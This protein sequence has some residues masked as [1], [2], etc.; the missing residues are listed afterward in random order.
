MKSGSGRVIGLSAVVFG[1][2]LFVLAPSA[3]G[4]TWLDFVEA[5]K[6][7]APPPPDLSNLNGTRN[8]KVSPDGRHLYS[9][10]PDSDA[11]NVFSRDD[12]TGQLT[13]IETHKDNVGGVDGLDSGLGLDI[14]PDGTHIYVASENDHG[15]SLFSRNPLTG[16]LTFMEIFQDGA[17]GID[18]LN[19]AHAV[20]ISPD[21]KHVYAG[22]RD[23]FGVFSRNQAT[24][25]LTFIEK[26]FD[27]QHAADCGSAWTMAVS[28]DGKHLYLA[29]DTSVTVYSRNETTGALTYIE[30]NF[31]G[32]TENGINYNFGGWA[33]GLS[34][35]P[36]GLNV[37]TT[38][39]IGGPNFY[40]FQRNPSTGAL[41]PIQTP[42]SSGGGS[43]TPAVEPFGHHVYLTNQWSNNLLVYSRSSVDGQLTYIEEHKDGVSGVDGLDT[44]YGAYVSP[45]GRHV[46]TGS[47][48]GATSAV[49]V[50]RASVDYALTV[51]KAGSGSGLV[52]S[53]PAG[54][55]C[56]A[57]CS[58][59]YV[60]DA[61][62]SLTADPEAGSLFVGWSGD[63]SGANPQIAIAMDGD[64]S[65]M[66]QFDAEAAA[67]PVVIRTYP[68]HQQ[69]NV[70]M[71]EVLWAEFSRDMAS[72]SINES[73]F[74]LDALNQS[75]TSVSGTISYDQQQRKAIFS[76]SDFL[77]SGMEYQARLTTEVRAEDGMPLNQDYEWT[78]TTRRTSAASATV[79]LPAGTRVSDYRIISMPLVPAET[80]G[81]GF[82]GLELG[83][84]D[85]GLW[86]IGRW[87][88]ASGRYDQYPFDETPGPGWAGW[89]LCRNGSVWNMT[90]TSTP[91]LAGPSGMTGHVVEVESGWNQIGN[92]FNQ[93][94]NTAEVWVREVG[95][96]WVRIGEAG[97]TITQTVFWI[98]LNGRYQAAATLASTEG[99]WI[100][101]LTEG[102]GE[103]FFPV[104]EPLPDG[105]AITRDAPADLERP[106]DPPG[107]LDQSS[108]LSGG[109]GGGGGCFIQT[110][111]DRPNR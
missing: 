84:Y 65:C 15:L 91:I 55:D 100:K 89:F 53:S 51:F 61:G 106:P 43:I 75:T 109:G 60:Q 27:G 52:A 108:A 62:I 70:L 94:V 39:V 59:K 29:G 7:D 24:G 26:H 38:S 95:G 83:V 49:S 1:V 19:Q 90:G 12:A 58:K 85:T 50:F 67:P 97:N 17:D 102:H 28:P 3:Q 111:I 16:Q 77:V 6:A 78:F 40:V 42:F 8:V 44:A 35:S 23:E 107:G 87:N 81:N 11:L 10:A 80:S 14:S 93:A 103:V 46:Y 72:A 69:D 63:A 37:Y 101:K 18:G 68:E 13:F 22:G 76:P 30:S 54:I 88:P 66:A 64:K 98:Y 79:S 34:I 20:T 104:Q 105:S 4:Q 71:N 21:G 73:S 56:G 57:S 110:I 33:Y 82:Y 92:P 45:D 47:F 99:G 48:S 31:D 36:D 96:T 9:T 74:K 5:H 41:I 32:D 86:R 2:L 25:H